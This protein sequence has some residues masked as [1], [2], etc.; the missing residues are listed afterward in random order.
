MMTLW[1]AL[2]AIGI[3]A[4]ATWA[5]E[6]SSLSAKEIPVLV[7]LA[8]IAGLGRIPFAAIPNV[9]P[10]TCVVLLTG[11]VFGPLAGMVVG[12]VAAWISDCFLGQGPWVLWQMLAWGLGGWV[13][14]WIGR[15]LP[16][17]GRGTLVVLGLVWGYCFGWIM[18][19]W[20]WASFIYPLTWRSWLLVNATSFWF[21][22]FHAVG[23]SLFAWVLGHDLLKI[24]KR[25][26]DKLRVTSASP[27]W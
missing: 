26:H 9:Q 1:I 11:L 8:A 23:N 16:R 24:V 12:M 3:L 17:S 2:G 14:G 13:A 22:T 15:L 21:D 6:R 4:A 10:T 5:Y 19:L 27:V 20:Y 7:V 18:N 25:F